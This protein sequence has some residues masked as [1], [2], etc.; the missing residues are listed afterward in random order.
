MRKL[1]LLLLLMIS[2]NVSAE[3]TRVTSVNNGEI[4]FYVD[5]DTIKKKGHKVQMWKLL[6]YKTVQVGSDVVRYL[7]MF[8]RDE[9]D[10]E[11]KTTRTLDL[12]SYSGNMKSGDIVSSYSNI[13]MEAESIIPV[14]IDEVFF[15]IA[16]GKK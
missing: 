7:S 16:C 2:T 15:K 3:W 4:T 12:Y 11:E 6:D 5:Y 9:D 13:K 8:S 1:T 10:C 14:S